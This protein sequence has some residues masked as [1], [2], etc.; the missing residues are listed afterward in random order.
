MGG[1]GDAAGAKELFA[2]PSDPVIIELNRLQN[3]ILE[4]E[5]ELGLAK[6]EIKALKGTEILKDKAIMELSNQLKKRDEKLGITEK[7]LEQKNLDIKKLTNETKEALAAQISAE[8]ILR[9]VYANQKDE[10]LTP[11]EVLIAPLQSDIKQYRNEI[12]MLQED[13]KALER[14]TKSKEAAL[15]EAES[16]LHNAL[17][18]ARNVE[19]MKNKNLELKRQ[20]EIC[21]EENKI[22]EKTYKKKV[23]EVEKLM[24]TIHELEEN[25]LAGGASANAIRDYQRKISEINEE[26]R[27][28][29]R[30][31]ARV[32]V[33]ASRIATAAANEWKD[34][35]DKVIPVKQW[36]EERRILQGEIQR[37]KDKLTLAGR[38]L[39]A[40]T[41]LKEKL[42]LRLKT[43][44]Q[45]MKHSSLP[46]KTR[47]LCE[48]KKCELASPKDLKKVSHAPNNDTVLQ[49]PNLNSGDVDNARGMVSL[50]SNVVKKNSL[51][52]RSRSFND[53]GK[54]NAETNVRSNRY[55]DDV[56][57]GRN[58]VNHEVNEKKCGDSKSQNEN[59]E[60]GYEDMVSGFLYDKLQKKVINLR[61]SHKDK[62]NVLIMK[63]E[64][65][66]FLLR[67]VDVLTK[68]VEV[69]SKKKR[70]NAREKEMIKLENNKH[71][72][73][74]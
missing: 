60:N 47:D 9:R 54:E 56:M 66:K 13:I 45:C 19:V 15:V 53:A 6:N 17:E 31:L 41:Q 51:A 44:E 29:E 7:Q 40:E 58:Q 1:L 35:G 34:D 74:I 73:D 3:S 62:D 63:D 69:E 16:L 71:N 48:R 32:K 20:I 10:E 36:L 72:I 22:L 23:V 28:V 38:T 42:S 14:L 30:E 50:N 25:I 4:K 46:E 8:A 2:S 65:I 68:A 57:T 59:Q 70:R 5:R 55:A 24:K 12:V 11:I 27:M 26:K 64:E 18:Q 21:Q 61:E 33:S 39:K 43:L 67:K 52:L 49:K 37:L